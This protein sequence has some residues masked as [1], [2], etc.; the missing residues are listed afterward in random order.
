M[1]LITA[2]T[3]GC[4]K[5]G[6]LVNQRCGFCEDVASNGHLACPSVAAAVLANSARVRSTPA[7]EHA[8]ARDPG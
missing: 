8:Q 1:H 2:G 3:C 4:G 7:D 5:R 6:T